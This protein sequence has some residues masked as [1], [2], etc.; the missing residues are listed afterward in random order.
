MRAVFSRIAAG[1]AGISI[2]AACTGGQ[3]GIQPP[4]T[5]VNVQAQSTLQFRVGTVNFRAGAATL[6]NTVV[7]FRQPNGLSATLYNT[8][9]ITGPAGFVV[10]STINAGCLGTSAPGTSP[11]SPS[12]GTDA[13]TA[14]ISGTQ[15]TQPGTPAVATTFGQVGGAYAYGF[16]PANSNTSGTPFYP[17]NSA[18]RPFPSAIGTYTDIYTQPIYCA[19]SR[20]YPFVLG[21]P[22]VPDF[23]P[24]SAGFPAGFYGYDSGFTSFGVAPVTGTYS[25][26]VTV[27]G[28]DIGSFAG[29]FDQT[30]TLTNPVPLGNVAAPV[31]AEPTSP[32]GALTFTVA[33]APAGATSQVLY[34]VDQSTATFYSFN[35]GVAGGVFTLPAADF[36]AGDV[37]RSYAVAADWDIVGDAVPNNLSPAPALPAQTDTSISTVSSIAYL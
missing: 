14:S 13:G 26:H 3:S 36:A 5:A 28:P 32:G 11:S 18:G 12:P 33:P 24:A 21:P 35:A 1:A 4:S 30:A 17:G 25:I 2:L 20:R 37:V 16:A 22:A 23:H 27:P 9:T 15:P 31:V 6:F 7:T 8:P 19:S 29:V 10:P 34:I